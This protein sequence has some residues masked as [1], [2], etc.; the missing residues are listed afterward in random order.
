MRINRITA[1]YF[2]DGFT[3]IEIT[4]VIALMLSLSALVISLVNP[5]RDWRLG[6]D[7]GL[8]IQSVYVAQKTYLADHPNAD[9]ATLTSA[10]LLPYLPDGTTQMPVRTGLDDQALTLDFTQVPPVW[11]DGGTIYDP[12][13]P[14]NNGLWDVGN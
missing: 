2:P 8:A 13:P 10:M 3:L 7:A 5:M 6:K 1:N 9:P 14:G 12:S 11:K 4:V